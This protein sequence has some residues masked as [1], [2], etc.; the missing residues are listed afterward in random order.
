MYFTTLQ[1]IILLMLKLAHIWPAEALCGWI[2]N[3]F[4]MTSFVFG[5]F[6]GLY[7]GPR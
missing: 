1:L 6:L 5:S 2:L 4:D 7:V 3:P